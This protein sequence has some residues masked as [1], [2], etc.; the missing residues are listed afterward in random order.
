MIRIVFATMLLC[1]DGLVFAQSESSYQKDSSVSYA[2]SP[3]QLNPTIFNFDLSK[4]KTCLS[5]NI[6]GLSWHEDKKQREQGNQENPG[7]GLR[8][9]FSPHAYV[10][11]NYITKNT[12]RGRTASLGLGWETEVGRL[13]DNPLKVGGQILYLIY[14]VPTLTPAQKVKHGDSVIY[15][16]FVPLGTFSYALDKQTTLRLGAFPRKN[17]S[18]FLLGV[19]VHF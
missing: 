18:V 6:L 7:L 19:T 13:F 1:V 12:R 5:L 17:K 3:V 9:D 8:C 2:I 4:S 14:E 11:A 15:E 16:G 10:E